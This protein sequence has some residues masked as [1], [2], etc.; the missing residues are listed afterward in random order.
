MVGHIA[1]PEV[2]GSDIPATLSPQIVTELLREELSYQGIV[3][4]DAMDMGAVTNYYSAEEA[5]VQAIQAGVDMILMPSDFE[6]AYQGVLLAVQNGIISEER[7][8]E[9]LKRIISLKIE[10]QEQK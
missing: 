3:I 6:A 9:S 8:D 7:L 4:T 2:T 5:A 10:L 1:L